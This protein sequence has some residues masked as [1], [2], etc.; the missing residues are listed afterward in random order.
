MEDEYKSIALIELHLQAVH[1]SAGLIGLRDLQDKL[2]DQLDDTFIK[3]LVGTIAA[4]VDSSLSAAGYIAGLAQMLS[5]DDVDRRLWPIYA[6]ARF[7]TAAVAFETAYLTNIADSSRRYSL[8]DIYNTLKRLLLHCTAA[9]KGKQHA[10]TCQECIQTLVSQIDDHELRGLCRLSA[11]QLRLPPTNLELVVKRMDAY[12]YGRKSSEFL[13]LCKPML[14]AHPQVF[15]LYELYAAASLDEGQ[16]LESPFLEDTV[17]NEILDLTFAMIGRTRKFTSLAP[18]FHKLSYT[19]DG[20]AIG[21]GMFRLYLKTYGFQHYLGRDVLRI[22]SAVAPVPGHQAAFNDTSDKL[23]FL[24][25]FNG[26]DPPN[27]RKR[28]LTASR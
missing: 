24:K 18:R 13:D 3:Y 26:D 19:L 15:E 22:C 7:R 8:D 10:K 16:K 21:L 28:T 9:A 12:Y 27:P 4:K 2:L 11:P 20:H 6:E 17:A 1:E 23:E 25:T 14:E 5:T